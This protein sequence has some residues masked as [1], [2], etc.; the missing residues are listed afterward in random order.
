MSILQGTTNELVVRDYRTA[1]EWGEEE[2]SLALKECLEDKNLLDVSALFGRF[3]AEFK[4]VFGVDYR[5]RDASK[6][7]EIDAK[8]RPLV[9]NCKKTLEVFESLKASL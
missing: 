4:A 7:A 8:W 1:S 9:N 5:K 2:V 6:D 3:N